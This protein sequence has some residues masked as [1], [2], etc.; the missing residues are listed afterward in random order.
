MFAQLPPSAIVFCRPIGVVL[1]SC[2]GLVGC[3]SLD[4]LPQQADPK[5]DTPSASSLGGELRKPTPPGQMLGI[6]DRA[7]EIERNL[8]VR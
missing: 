8:G 1:L 3:A 4:T 5:P 6:D 7:R 2:L